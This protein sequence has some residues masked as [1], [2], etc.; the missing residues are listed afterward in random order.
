MIEQLLAGKFDIAQAKANADAQAKFEAT[1]EALQASFK[2]AMKAQKWDEATKFVDQL[3]AMIPEDKPSIPMT[4]RLDVGI[5]R[6]DAQS[7]NKIVERLLNLDSAV[8]GVPINCMQAAAKIA[9][10]DDIAGLNMEATERLARRGAEL[11]TG[12]QRLF[13]PQALSSLARLVF[14]RGRK[15]EAIK[16]QE[17]AIAAEPSRNDKQLLIAIRDAYQGGKLPPAPPINLG[18]GRN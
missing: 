17:E 2:E 9:V 12:Q 8:F 11:A 13:R 1:A 6:K 14:R 10:A 16:I 7:V 18:H 15:D 3:A 4:E 5:A